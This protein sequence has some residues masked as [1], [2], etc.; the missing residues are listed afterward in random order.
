VETTM[1]VANLFALKND[2]P[3]RQYMCLRQ[4]LKFRRGRELRKL[5]EARHCDRNEAT[6][7]LQYRA[8]RLSPL[9]R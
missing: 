6:L 4:W 1:V 3:E 5:G 2:Q 8:G 9:S 7:I